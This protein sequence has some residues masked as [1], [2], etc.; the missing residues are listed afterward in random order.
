MSLGKLDEEA[1]FMR[2]EFNCKNAV[3]I[4][5]N[6]VFC[7]YL[8]QLF[9]NVRELSEKT[10]SGVY[11][12]RPRMDCLNQGINWIK[13]YMRRT[14]LWPRTGAVSNPF[15]RPDSK[16]IPDVTNFCAGNWRGSGAPEAAAAAF[17]GL[18]RVRYATLPSGR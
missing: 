9:K 5:L 8:T 7:L 12:D 17:P 2:A 10:M 4:T 6:G 16:S 11:S 13:L 1:I 14:I 18:D 3:F 15:I